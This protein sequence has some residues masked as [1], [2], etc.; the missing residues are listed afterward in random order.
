MNVKQNEI[1]VE[2]NLDYFK[3]WQLV[4]KHIKRSLCDSKSES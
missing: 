1:Y 3:D 2:K 4:W